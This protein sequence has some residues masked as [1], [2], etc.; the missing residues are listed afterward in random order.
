MNWVKSIPN[1]LHLSL[2]NHNI[3]KPPQVQVSGGLYIN[4]GS[5]FIIR[6]HHSWHT[7]CQKLPLTIACPSQIPTPIINVVCIPCT[8][9]KYGRTKLCTKNNTCIIGYP[10][11]CKS[12]AVIQLTLTKVI[13]SI[14]NRKQLTPF[15]RIKLTSDY[16][17]SC[18]HVRLHIYF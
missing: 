6:A 17:D 12:I 18:I 4:I 14:P 3:F 10:V 8:T 2:C 9:A 1:L 5:T 7:P 15:K 11:R 16:S 13:V